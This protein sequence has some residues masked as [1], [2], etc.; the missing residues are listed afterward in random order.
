MTH[1]PRTR[2]P[3]TRAPYTCAEAKARARTLRA[4]LAAN[5]ETISH[6]AALERVAKD[7]GFA[8]W[9]TLSARLSNA[10]ETPLRVGDR[11]EGSYLKQAFAGRVLA[12]RSLN[13]GA[14]FR[15]TLAFDEPVDVVTWES[16]SAFR[17]RVSATIRPDGASPEK[18]SD[19]VP[20]L[21]VTRTA[22]ELV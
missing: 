4:A 11:V 16:F 3:H 2:V 8:D 15:V 22:T 14:A 18:T 19:G 5:G 13:D 12:V 6:S 1:A 21:I 20:H 7:C 9:N 17:R 10:P